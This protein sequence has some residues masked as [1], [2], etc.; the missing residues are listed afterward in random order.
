M[1]QVNVSARRERKLLQGGDDRCEI[2]SPLRDQHPWWNG[3]RVH[4]VARLSPGSCFG[5]P[6]GYQQKG[7]PPLNRQPNVIEK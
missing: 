1:I 5:I 6:D 7:Y 3:L 4:L 2:N